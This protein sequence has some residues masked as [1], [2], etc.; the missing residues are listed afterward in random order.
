MS[1]RA[2]GQTTSGEPAAGGDE[3]PGQAPSAAQ[4]ARS[5]KYEA[6]R[7]TLLDAGYRYLA[8]GSS[9]RGIVLDVLADCSLSTRAFYRHFESRD[10]FL[11]TMLRDD[12]DR[13]TRWLTDIVDQTNTGEEALRAYVRAFLSVAYEARRARR[14][15]ALA[16]EEVRSARGR[17][18]V[19]AQDAEVKRQILR[20]IFELGLRDGTIPGAEPVADAYALNVLLVS[21]VSDRLAGVHVVSFRSAVDHTVALFLR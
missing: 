21:Y 4:V 1:A 2:K 19:A 16:S 9:E 12:G 18:E 5:E 14:V 20:G 7:R 6:E 3:G 11:L 17:T 13:V 15:R 8:R 10:E